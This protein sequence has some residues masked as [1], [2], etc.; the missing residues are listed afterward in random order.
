MAHIVRSIETSAS[1]EETWKLMSD[2]RRLPEFVDDIDEMTVVPDGDVGVGYTYRA[3]EGI[4]PFKS[5]VTWSV[6]D[7]QPMRHQ[8]HHGE[9]G[10]MRMDLTVD[11]VPLDDSRQLTL[12]VD[13]QP[14]W[15]V[16]PLNWILWPAL[17]RKRAQASMD[18]TME[19]IAGLLDTSAQQAA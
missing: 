12:T 15:F 16:R 11:V 14:R 17:M 4:P 13:L 10:M 7:F 18:R 2:I 8:V 9:D 3:I 19:N 5:E 6:T 1:V